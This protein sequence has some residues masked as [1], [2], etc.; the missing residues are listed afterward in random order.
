[1]ANEENLMHK[2]TKEENSRGGI[3][4]GETKRRNKAFQD[5]LWAELDK[6]ANGGDKTQLTEIMQTL[7]RMAINGDSKSIELIAKIVGALK[8]NKVELDTDNFI[9]KL[10]KL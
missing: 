9:V 1:M 7:V 2:L 10:G 3:K 8:D 6:V 5:A 4:S